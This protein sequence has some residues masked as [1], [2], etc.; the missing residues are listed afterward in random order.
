M[1]RFVL[2]EMNTHRAF[3]RNSASSRAIPVQKIID[4]V[5]NDPAWPVVWPKE[6]AGMQGGEEHDEEVFGVH[7]RTYGMVQGVLP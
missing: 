5:T 1:H 4:R 2:A 7:S 3:S 6:Q